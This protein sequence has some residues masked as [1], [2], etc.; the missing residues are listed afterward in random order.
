[1]MNCRSGIDRGNV[2]FCFTSTEKYAMLHGTA[3]L[4]LRI[5]DIK[6][7]AF[8]SPFH[9]SGSIPTPTPTPQGIKL[10]WREHAAACGDQLPA[11]CI[12]LREGIVGEQCQAGKHPHHIL[13]VIA[14]DFI[15][16][17]HADIQ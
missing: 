13:V 9:F 6:R 7:A 8:W 12:R 5:Q 17:S 1:M 4:H 10:P 2:V 15:Y 16:V 3:G 11:V 14:A